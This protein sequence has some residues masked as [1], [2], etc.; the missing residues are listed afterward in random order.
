MILVQTTAKTISARVRATSSTTTD[1]ALIVHKSVHTAARVQIHSL[2][3]LVTTMQI[4]QTACA[5]VI[6]GM[7]LQTTR[8]ALIVLIFLYSVWLVHRQKLVFAVKTM[9]K[10]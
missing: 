9:L 7:H 8:V 1:T 5:E 2:A 10:I 6:S 3:H 4:P